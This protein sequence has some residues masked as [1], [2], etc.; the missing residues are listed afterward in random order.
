MSSPPISDLTPV[1]A[2]EQAIKASELLLSELNTFSDLEAG[3]QLEKTDKLTLVR[4][5]L[6]KQVFTHNWQETEVTAHN[7][8]FEKLEQLNIQLVE[9]AASVR[10][11]LHQQRVDNQQGRKAVSAYGTAKGQFHR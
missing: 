2:L 6:I 4:D 11:N 7:A 5:Q 8:A 10:H 1:E 9:Q 3:T